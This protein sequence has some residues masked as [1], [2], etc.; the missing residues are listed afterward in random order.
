MRKDKGYKKDFVF[1]DTACR[2]AGFFVFD[3]TPM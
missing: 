1:I 2:F 3:D